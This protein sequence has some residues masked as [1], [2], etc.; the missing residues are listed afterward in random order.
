MNQL[1]KR[2]FTITILS[3][4]L[5]SLASRAL[6]A[7]PPRFPTTAVVASSTCPARG[8]SSSSSLRMTTTTTTSSNG[9]FFESLNGFLQER[10]ER[11][12]SHV[13]IG[14]PAGD[15]DSIL[16]ALT[17]A[18]VQ[19]KDSKK[20]PVVSISR[21]DLLTQRPETLELFKLAG[22]S[23][24]RVW[25]RDDSLSSSPRQI[26]LVDHNRWDDPDA[27][28]VEIWDHHLDEGY[29]TDTCQTRKIAFEN[30]KSTLR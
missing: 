17:L 3:L 16:S 6:V 12:T 9:V 27:Q 25:C 21:Q 11:P 30:G 1:Q 13:V 5:F 10:K 20:T 2:T 7:H 29:H 19:Q 4:R 24:E 15:A 28:I 18:F 23:T 14:N 26:T 22:I 8:S